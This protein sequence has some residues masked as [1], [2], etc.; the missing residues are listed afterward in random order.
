MRL[1]LTL[2]C[3]TVP[4]LAWAQQPTPTEEE[5]EEPVV[6]EE[7]LP[8]QVRA[9]REKVLES[10]ARLLMLPEEIHGTIPTQAG[11]RLRV[12]NELPGDYKLEKI[13][14][15]LNNVAVVDKTLTESD[16]PS[17]FKHEQ[18]LAP[19]AHTLD[20]TLVYRGHGRG[21]FP[22]MRA[23]EVIIEGSYPFVVPTRSWRRSRRP[24]LPISPSRSCGNSGLH[25]VSVSRKT[26]SFRA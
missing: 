24:C 5:V 7:E 10:R 15:K 6:E 22:Y 18:P 8:E 1:L 13:V 4:V 9:L 21:L 25:F 14:A 20:L 17:L 2:L 11:L 12:D 19:G 3:L 23:Y 16:D 26:R